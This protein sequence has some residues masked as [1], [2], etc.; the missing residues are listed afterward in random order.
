[1]TL[2]YW[3]GIDSVYILNNH[4]QS[5]AY[6]MNTNQIKWTVEDLNIALKEGNEMFVWGIKLSWSKSAN[7]GYLQNLFTI[8]GHTK[9]E[10]WKLK[11]RY[12]YLQRF[13]IFIRALTVMIEKWEQR[14]LNLKVRFKLRFP[15]T[16]ISAEERAI[17]FKTG[18]V[19]QCNLWKKLIFYQSSKDLF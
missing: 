3:I 4:G 9:F 7:F 13:E 5:C 14:V 2:M 1:M 12:L 18:H 15:A 10:E 16:C 11:T 8:N 19:I 6:A 17:R